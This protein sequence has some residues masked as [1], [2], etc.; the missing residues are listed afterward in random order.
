MTRI[1]GC[2]MRV[3]IASSSDP[4]MTTMASGFC[5]WAP[6]PFESAA[7]NSPSIATSVVMSTGRNRFSDASRAACSMLMPST[8]CRR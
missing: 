3:R 6:M 8:S 1:G 4:P 5:V 7:G 2:R